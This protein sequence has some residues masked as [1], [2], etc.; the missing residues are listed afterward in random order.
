MDFVEAKN[1][2]A[3]EIAL[4][5]GVPPMLLGI[6]GDNTYSNYQEAQRAFW[7]GT[8]LPLIARMTKAFSG[9]LGARLRRARRVET[10]PRP[11]GGLERPSA[12]RCG[13]RLDKATFL[14][15]NE[16]RAAVGYGPVDAERPATLASNTAPISRACRRASPAAGNGRM[17]A[18][19][20]RARRAACA[21]RRRILGRGRMRESSAPQSQAGTPT[22]C[23][24][25]GC[26]AELECPTGEIADQMSRFAVPGQDPSQPVKNG[27]TSLVRDP[28][29]ELPA[30]YVDTF[31]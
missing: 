18:A 7:R 12:R 6:P 13:R 4:A 28:T 19:A 30:G 5:L 27:T 16:K 1:A 23:S 15:A 9:W 17:A 29:T 24:D 22:Q 3:R 20:S 11:G 14:T 10:R 25:E 31:V 8:V 2:S 26:S 21:S